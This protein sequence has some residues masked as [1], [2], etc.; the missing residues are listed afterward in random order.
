MTM[1]GDGINPSPAGPS[2]S[3]EPVLPLS[4]RATLRMPKADLPLR[5]YD[6][7]KG[8]APLPVGAKPALGRSGF[9]RDPQNCG[10]FAPL[11]LREA[12]V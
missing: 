1:A 9:G 11:A 10:E 3:W 4:E 7:N 2:I 6:Q 5:I 8:F 12:A